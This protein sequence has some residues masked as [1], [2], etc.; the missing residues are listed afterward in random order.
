MK[1]CNVCGAN[2]VDEICES[3]TR[4]TILPTIHYMIEARKIMRDK[5]IPNIPLAVLNYFDG[6]SVRQLEAEDAMRFLVE[7]VYLYGDSEM[8]SI[9]ISDFNHMERDDIIELLEGF[10]ETDYQV[11]CSIC[12]SAVTF[13]YAHDIMNRYHIIRDLEKMRE[14]IK[15]KGSDSIY[16]I[17]ALSD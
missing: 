1:H 16:N 12:A 14:L 5:N 4:Q 13:Y 2:C 11:P 7:F 9:C 10:M 15:L 17:L 3:H 6:D 8:L